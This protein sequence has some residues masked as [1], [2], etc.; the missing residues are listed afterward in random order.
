MS[1]TFLEIGRRLRDIRASTGLSQAE[2]ADFL[3]TS[4]RSY[5]A[6]ETGK[7]KVTTA[8]VLKVEEIPGVSR[9]WL[10]SGDNLELKDKDL[11]ILQE[12]LERG[13]TE[14]KSSGDDID[15]KTWAQ[16]LRLAIKLGLSQ[17]RSL[18]ASDIAEI[19][20]SH[21]GQKRT[22]SDDEHRNE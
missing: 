8:I 19:V 13:L 18:H 16:K 10:L 11:E 7:R 2:F 20:G 3:G 9:G 14:L 1:T 12:T 6:Y 4:Y 22:N 15:P 17:N 21:D 5:R